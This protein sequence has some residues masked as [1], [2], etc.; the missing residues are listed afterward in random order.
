MGAEVGGL[1]LGAC[2]PNEHSLW[3]AGWSDSPQWVERFASPS[4]GGRGCVGD[5]NRRFMHEKTVSCM[6]QTRYEICRLKR[7]VMCV[8]EPIM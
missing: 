7:D 4:E 5:R 3:A 6:S 2:G 8:V 1:P